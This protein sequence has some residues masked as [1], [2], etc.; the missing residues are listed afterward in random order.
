MNIRAT[1]V[2]VVAA[3]LLSGCSNNANPKRQAAPSLPLTLPVVRTWGEL[4]SQAAIELRPDPRVKRRDTDPN[5]PLVRV[6]LGIESS[7][8]RLYGGALLY[9][10]TENYV[11]DPKQMPLRLR[12]G[13]RTLQCG[14]L[15]V[16]VDDGRADQPAELSGMVM[17]DIG[18]L[19]P[20]RCLFVAAIPGHSAGKRRVLVYDSAGRCVARAD[21]EVSRESAHAWTIWGRPRRVAELEEARPGDP[22]DLIVH[23][24]AVGGDG[25]ATP[26]WD[27]YGCRPLYADGAVP[28]APARPKRFRALPMPTS[29]NAPLP[30]FLPRKVDRAL[31]ASLDGHTLKIDCDRKIT[32][33]RPDHHFLVRWWVNGK[34]FVPRPLREYE[35][36]NGGMLIRSRHLHLR[37][38]FD[39]AKLGAVKGD[40][41]GLQLLYCHRGWQF[42]TPDTVEMLKLLGDRERPCLPMLSNRVEF[43]AE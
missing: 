22:E 27:S 31:R 9:V 19:P 41:I 1:L 40:R 32:M 10:L 14:P 37:M 34:P 43:V 20:R 15:R 21:F 24:V 33:S 29:P 8:C 23:H 16:A 39:S 7:T 13:V 11:P 17:P 18:E 30:T 3:A 36:D 35:D 26:E 5:T 42:C 25:A 2:V 4:F 38:Q 28:G 6:R 12:R